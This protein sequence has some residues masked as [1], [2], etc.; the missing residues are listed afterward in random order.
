MSDTVGGSDMSV[1][2][3][4]VFGVLAVVG[5]VG[6]LVAYENQVVAGWS[7]A[8]AMVAGV[9]SVAGVHLFGDGA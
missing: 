5:A 2:L 8:L 4:L 9:L 7:F 1:G 6:M 3:G